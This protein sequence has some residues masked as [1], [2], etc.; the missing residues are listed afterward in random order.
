MDGQ[1]QD[2]PGCKHLVGVNLLNKCQN[3]GPAAKAN[4][5]HK[6]E[7]ND[8]SI[9]GKCQVPGPAQEGRRLHDRSVPCGNLHHSNALQKVNN[10]DCIPWAQGTEQGSFL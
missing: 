8:D 2:L 1:R 10:G 4:A 9:D 5:S 6:D 3:G 7:H